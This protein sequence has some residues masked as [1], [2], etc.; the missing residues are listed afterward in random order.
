MAIRRV[1]GED[2]ATPVTAQ[3][4]GEHTTMDRVGFPGN[5]VF[6]YDEATPLETKAEREKLTADLFFAVQMGR[7]FI[8]LVKQKVLDA[9]IPDLLTEYTLNYTPDKNDAEGIQLLTAS[10]DL[11]PDGFMLYQDIITSDGVQTLFEKWMND[12]A[13]PNGDQLLFKDIALLFRSWHERNYSQPDP[14]IGSAWLPQQLEYQFS[15]GA[16]IQQ[17]QQKVLTADQYSEGHLDWYSFDLNPGRQLPSI[18]NL[19]A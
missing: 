14:E 8:R 15:V 13:I 18:R 7:Y 17:Q 12:T 3:I 1:P 5:T 16:S 4:L 2:A 19:R 6:G 11:L 9:W 10:K